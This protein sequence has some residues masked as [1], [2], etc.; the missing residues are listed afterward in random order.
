MNIQQ[1]VREKLRKDGSRLAL[2]WNNEYEENLKLLERRKKE[3]A[4]SSKREDFAHH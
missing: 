4:K 3:K 2:K 1:L